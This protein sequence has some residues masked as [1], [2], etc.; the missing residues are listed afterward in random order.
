M[1]ILPKPNEWKKWLLFIFF[2]K[3]SIFI[4]FCSVAVSNETAQGFYG[5]LTGDTDSY[6]VPIEN[7]INNGEYRPDYRMP[8]YGLIYLPFYLTLPKVY[9]LN[10]LILFQLIIS[11]VSIYFLGLISKQLFIEDSYFYTTIFCASLCLYIDRVT[12]I[13]GSDSLAISFLILSVYFFFYFLKHRRYFSLIFCGLFLTE[14]IFL[15]P[16]FLP[17][18]FLFTVYLIIHEI[19]NKGKGLVIKMTLLLFPFIIFDGMWTIRNYYQHN[20]FAPLT[21]SIYY[22]H[23][24]YHV[25]LFNFFQSWGGAVDDARL[26][27]EMGIERYAEGYKS[28]CIPKYIYTSKFNLDSLKNIG[29]QTITIHDSK[30]SQFEKNNSIIYINKQLKM[31]TYSIKEEKPWLFFVKAPLVLL[32]KFLLPQEIITFFSILDYKKFGIKSFFLLYHHIF[33]IIILLSGFLGILSFYKQIL[34]FDKVLI[35][36]GI[37]IYTITVHPLI[38]RLSVP[39]YFYP[40]WP[41]MVI[42]A[43]YFLSVFYKKLLLLNNIISCSVKF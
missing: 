33:Y 42:C 5:Y 29:K 13:A 11:V 39:R 15:R 7:L 31:Y 8:G 23:Y 4:Y 27:A 32:R 26:Y 12:P 6:L 38:L 43:S 22:P 35:I 30:K 36:V 41:F 37:I 2:I 25:N 17:I 28:G 14:V 20:R 21:T 24:T 19:V 9:A 10:G 16:V 34:K 3:L 1:S 40:A 18:Y